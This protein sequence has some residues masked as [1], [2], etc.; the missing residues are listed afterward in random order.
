MEIK[1]QRVP[2]AARQGS[3]R[4]TAVVEIIK[5]TSRAVHGS[6]FLG[7]FQHSNI[8]KKKKLKTFVLY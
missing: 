3:G 8:V 6:F 5:H 2:A 4:G 1:P 7:L